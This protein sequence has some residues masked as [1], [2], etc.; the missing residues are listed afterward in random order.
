MFKHC[1]IVHSRWRMD[2]GGNPQNYGRKPPPSVWHIQKILDE[3]AGLIKTIEA[4]QSAGKA[5]ESMS[6]QM[7]L[8]RNLVY[9]VNSA[10][11]KVNIPSLLPCPQTGAVHQQQQ[12]QQQQQ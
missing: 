4:F 5:S 6:F 3:N 11:P 12:R 9:L 10:D 7:M 2:R 8:H 1:C